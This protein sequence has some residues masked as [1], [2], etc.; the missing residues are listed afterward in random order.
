MTSRSGAG[1]RLLLCSD[2]LMNGSAEQAY[3]ATWLRDLLALPLEWAS[4][5][6]VHYLADAGCDAADIVLDRQ[7][8][9]D[10]SQLPFTPAE[11]LNAFDASQLAAGSIARL[12][13]L[14][15]E[16]DIVI[17]FELSEQTRDV[18][19]RVGVTYID[20][21]LH[22]VRF[23]ED[24]LFAFG[25]NDAGIAQSLVEFALD[26]RLLELR[27]KEICLSMV[28]SKQ[29]PSE[30]IPPRSALFVGQ[31]QYDKALLS[32][33]RMLSLLDYGDDFKALGN[34]HPKV[35]YS[36]HPLVHAGDG[37]T[38][39][40]IKSCSFV[41]RTA[42]P[43]YA[44]LAEPNIEAVYSIS[45]SVVHEARF[46]GK[47][48]EY[49]FQPPI[50]LTGD[51]RYRPV[52]DAFLTPQFWGGILAQVCDIRTFSPVDLPLK[53]SR[54]RDTLGM[55]YGFQHVDKLESL[56]HKLWWARDFRGVALRRLKAIVNG[57]KGKR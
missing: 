12:E 25:S 48:T 29:R 27:A 55:V 34:R 6:P 43:T 31:T 51:G 32:G 53:P 23:Y 54:M 20:F 36:R 35:L 42:S 14:F 10:S 28:R 15:T 2:F 38:A 41:S 50:P 37:S 24:I 19:N 46:F 26:E 57:L 45:S 21:W 44:L 39:R 52:R 22:P 9:F 18:L 47:Q 49:L 56:H 8:F 3:H 30:D 4:A 16:Q 13:E 5:A 33:G 11:K 17:G 40:F 7:S 1:A